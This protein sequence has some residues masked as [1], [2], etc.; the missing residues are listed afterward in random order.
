MFSQFPSPLRDQNWVAYLSNS[1][2]IFLKA[3]IGTVEKLTNKTLCRDLLIIYLHILVLSYDYNYNYTS[4]FIY[5]GHSGTRHHAF[6]CQRLLLWRRY[7]VYSWEC[8]QGNASRDIKTR[9]SD[10]LT[11]GCFLSLTYYS[12]CW[13]YLWI[14]S[15]AGHSHLC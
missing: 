12:Y 1:Q 10:F 14:M 2:K 7:F 6:P 4:L 5:S 9:S 11:Q 8:P 3:L 13:R 15:S